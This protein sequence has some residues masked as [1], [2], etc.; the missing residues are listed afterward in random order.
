MSSKPTREAAWK[1]I[2]EYLPSDQMRRHSLAVEAVMRHMA[3][4]YGED[5]E[6]WGVIGLAHDID[7]ERYP[8]AHCH[9]APEILKNAGWPEGYIR[10]VVSHGWGICSDVEPQTNLE[11]TLFTI[12][13]LTG[14]VAAS[15]LVRPSKSIL[16][17]PVKS[18]TKKWKDKAFAAGADRSI[19][20]KGAAMM[21]VELNELIADTIE[22]M[23]TEAEAIGLKGNL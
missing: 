22:G 12:D 21:G 2:E 19:I 17:L 18:V 15:A 1:L 13:E 3:K 20:E 7:Y 10:A 6:M 5:E 8:E 14:L 16:D 23:K 4:K 9:K 11:K